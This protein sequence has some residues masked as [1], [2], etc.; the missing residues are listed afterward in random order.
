[1]IY[2]SHKSKRTKNSNCPKCSTP[3]KVKPMGRNKSCT[4]KKNLTNK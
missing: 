1:M 3:T 2:S 4:S